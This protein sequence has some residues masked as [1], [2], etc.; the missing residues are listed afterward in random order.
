VVNFSGESIHIS[1]ACVSNFIMSSFDFSLS[2]SK[3]TSDISNHGNDMIDIV[4][5]GELDLDGIN[6]GGTKFRF[7]EFSKY[8]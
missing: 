3:I 6:K 7:S 2:E 8:I 4:T 1:S 5:G